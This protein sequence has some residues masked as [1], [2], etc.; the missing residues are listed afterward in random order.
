MTDPA[1]RNNKALK[2]ACVT[3]WKMAIEYAEQPRAAVI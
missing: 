3:K 2:K 1:Q